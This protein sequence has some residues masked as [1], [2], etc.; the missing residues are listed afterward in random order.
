MHA[1]HMRGRQKQCPVSGLE[2]RPSSAVAVLAISLC[3]LVIGCSC[4]SSCLRMC[5]L[6]G[7]SCPSP[8]HRFVGLLLVGRISKQC[9]LIGLHACGDL[10]AHVPLL[11]IDLLVSCLFRMT[12]E[13]LE[14]NTPHVSTAETPIGCFQDQTII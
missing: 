2:S 5:L 6:T 4:P 7:R 14:T 13:K 11:S 8:D 12:K 10:F 1:A 3:R 9:V